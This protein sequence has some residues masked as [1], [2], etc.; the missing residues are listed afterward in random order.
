LRIL[1][2]DDN[3]AVLDAL[4]LLLLR[5]GHTVSTAPDGH[6]GLARLEAGEPVDLVLADFDLPDISGIEVVR[7]VRSRWPHVRVG[8]MTG[9]MDELPTPREPVDML[10]SKPV[11]LYELREAITRLSRPHR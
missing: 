11:N 1:L 3:E 5:E 7:D 4:G 9:M 6:Q 8:I 10:F 2:I